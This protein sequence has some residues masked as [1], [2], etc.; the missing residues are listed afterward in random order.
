MKNQRKA[1]LR[2]SFFSIRAKIT[3]LCTCSI[4]VA[5]TVTFFYLVNVSKS[6]ITDSTEATMQELSD[7]YSKNLSDAVSQIS[8][9]VN[10]MMSSSAVSAFVEAGGEE[11][12]DAVKELVSMFLSSHTYN[13]DVSIVDADGIILYSSNSDL[14]GKDISGETYFTNMVS[15]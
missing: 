11:N 10:F 9:S 13:E 3:L 14:I 12:T 1:V 15:T 2:K 5:V 6:A 8:D 4:L 7:S